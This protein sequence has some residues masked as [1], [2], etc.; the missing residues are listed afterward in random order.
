MLII[1]LLVSRC[2]RPLLCS[3]RL[4]RGPAARCHASQ[5][6]PA[7]PAGRHISFTAFPPAPDPALPSIR[8][9]GGSL[10]D[11]YLGQGGGSPDTYQRML[12]EGG[13]GGGRGSL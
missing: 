1:R 8:W 12:L 5:A 7:A 3:R 9:R 4:S 11:A 6:Y 13:L 10:L 2:C